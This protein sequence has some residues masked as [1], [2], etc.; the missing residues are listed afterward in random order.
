MQNN[1]KYV[2]ER[3]VS[4]ITGRALA[5]LRNDRYVGQGIPY[6]KMGRSVRYRLDDVINYMESHKVKTNRI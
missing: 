1:I 6:V 4:Q 2:D 5:T 3:A